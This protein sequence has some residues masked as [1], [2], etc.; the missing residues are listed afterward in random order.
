MVRA[1][2]EA[3]YD[4]RVL[5]EPQPLPECRKRFPDVWDRLTTKPH[6]VFFRLARR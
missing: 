2:D 6:F 3:G 1:F 5:R 4:V